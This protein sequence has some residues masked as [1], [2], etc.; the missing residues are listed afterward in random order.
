M[1]LGIGWHRTT[2]SRD[3]EIGNRNKRCKLDTWCRNRICVLLCTFI[4]TLFMRFN[5]WDQSKHPT[6]KQRHATLRLPATVR[7]IKTFDCQTMTNNSAIPLVNI[8]IMMAR[9]PPENHPAL[10]RRDLTKSRDARWLSPRRDEFG[11]HVVINSVLLVRRQ[12]VY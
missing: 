11:S 1:I 5:F 10:R 3:T 6:I 9:Y 2:C 4:H 12:S 8:F 7:W